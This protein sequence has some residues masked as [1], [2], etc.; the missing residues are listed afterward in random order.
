MHS[1]DCNTDHALFRVQ[2]KRFHHALPRPLPTVDTTHDLSHVVRFQQLLS[3]KF[4]CTPISVDP[5]GAWSRFH[6]VVFNSFISTF[7]HRSRTQPD[8]FQKCR[9]INYYQHSRPN[10]V[11]ET[12]IAPLTQGPQECC[13]KQSPVSHM[14]CSATALVLP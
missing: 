1:A 4:S 8:W 7:V 14:S 2:P 3:G 12:D 5:A 6:S 10:V 11:L 13:Q 9:H